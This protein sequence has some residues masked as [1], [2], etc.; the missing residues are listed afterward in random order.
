MKSLVRMV[1]KS[2]IGLFIDDEFLAVAI[3]CPAS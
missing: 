3:V 2:L 1:S